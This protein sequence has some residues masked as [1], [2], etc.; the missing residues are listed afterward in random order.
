MA[1]KT[2]LVSIIANNYNYGRFLRQAID[3]ALN[4][5]HADTEVIVVDDGSTDD[6]RKIIAAYG[7]RITPVLKDNGG[8]TSALNAGYAICRGQVVCFLDADDALSPTAIERAVSLIAEPNVAKVHWPLWI[9]D[10]HG[11]QTGNMV[12]SSA[13][14]EGNLRD[15]VIREGP[16]RHVY[17]PT[18]GNAWSR[19]FLEKVFPIPENKFKF[20]ADAYLGELA[21]LFGAIR[22]IKEPQGVYRV[23]G[24]NTYATIPLEE[25]L[26]FHLSR[27][28]FFCDVLSDYCRDMGVVADRER[29]KRNSWFQRVILSL[30][31]ITAC[32]PPEDT[33][34]LVDED[35]WGVGETIH[36]RRCIPFLERDG[37][38]WGK[39]AD[40]GGA[41]REVERLWKAGANYMVFAWPAFWWLEYYSGL[42]QHLRSN[43]RCTLENDRLI[44]FDLR[45]SPHG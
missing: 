21:P 5:T 36:G 10:Q 41:I 18:S 4:Q 7:G 2:Q 39:P 29:W 3:S 12:P 32:I 27:Y 19:A 14:P 15:I 24:A 43:F 34:I 45:L 28:D 11:R 35:S 44:V 25:K 42:N 37:Q 33:F 1:N 9:V 38:Y 22:T 26:E 20:S 6:S 31:D 13:L 23:H 30:Q 17:S 16:D 40:S 8:Q